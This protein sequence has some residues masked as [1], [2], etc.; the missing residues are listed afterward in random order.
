MKYFLFAEKIGIS[1]N[2]LP[3]EVADR[4]IFIRFRKGLDKF[5]DI[6]SEKSHEKRH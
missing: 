4:D 1:W 5:M 2:I 6:M 3:Q